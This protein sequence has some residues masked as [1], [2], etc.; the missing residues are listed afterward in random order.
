M[1]WPFAAD[2]FKSVADEVAYLEDSTSQKYSVVINRGIVQKRDIAMLL[3]E[4]QSEA[5]ELWISPY[6]ENTTQ[7]LQRGDIIVTESNERIKLVQRIEYI[8]LFVSNWLGQMLG[9][10]TQQK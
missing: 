2:D 9:K 4:N 7:Q 6:D 8:D 1:K 5:C 10:A 3:I